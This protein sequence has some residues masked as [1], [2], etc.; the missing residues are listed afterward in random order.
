MSEILPEMYIGLHV[1]YPLFLLDL[2]KLEFPR[3]ILEKYSSV[4]FYG[5]PSSASRISPCGRTDRQTQT[6][7]QALFAILRTRLETDPLTLCPLHRISFSFSFFI[8]LPFTCISFLLICFSFS[9]YIFPTVFFSR[10]RIF[11]FL[12]Y[13]LPYF[14]CH[15][16]VCVFRSSNISISRI[17]HSYKDVPT[18]TTSPKTLPSESSPRTVNA[19]I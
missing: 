10:K 1:K 14:I 13:F 12:G 7:Y 9:T 19:R 8:F 15:F 5:N 3:P 11:P 16:H 2:L 17:R 4:K 6:G 18:S